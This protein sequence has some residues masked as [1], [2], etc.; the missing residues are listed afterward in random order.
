MYSAKQ[1]LSDVN[2]VAKEHADIFKAKAEEKANILI[3]KP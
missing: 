1:K 3:T 2:A